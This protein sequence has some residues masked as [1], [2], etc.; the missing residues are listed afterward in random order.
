MEPMSS[1]S[2]SRRVFDSEEANTAL[3]QSVQDMQRANKALKLTNQILMDEKS[4]NMRVCGHIDHIGR[5][6][7]ILQND[8]TSGDAVGCWRNRQVQKQVE[9][10]TVSVGLGVKLELGITDPVS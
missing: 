9:Y 10:D 3:E 2:V 8:H 7:K 5:G 1:L 4:E 6:C